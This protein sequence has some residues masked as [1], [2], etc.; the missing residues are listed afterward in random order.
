MNRRF[1]LTSGAALFYA[2]NSKKNC[3]I[4]Y[5]LTKQEVFD[6][7]FEYLMEKK[8]PLKEGVETLIPEDSREEHKELIDS[9]EYLNTDSP[10]WNWPGHFCR[11]AQYEGLKQPKVNISAKK[12]K[13]EPKSYKPTKKVYLICKEGEP[14]DSANFDGGYSFQKRHPWTWQ[15]TYKEALDAASNKGWFILE[16]VGFEED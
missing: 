16:E 8:E 13:L 6:T 9:L 3:N 15:T 11:L 14:I 12:K 1:G 4:T 5:M 10:P 2:L 7:V